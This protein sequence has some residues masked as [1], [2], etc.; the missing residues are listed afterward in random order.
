MTKE[1]RDGRK[2]RGLDRDAK[3]DIWHHGCEEGESPAEV[4]AR[5]DRL[6]ENIKEIQGPFLK[7]SGG[8]QTEGSKDV[9]IIAHG[10]I[11]RAF[12]KRWVQYELKMR[13]PMMLEP[14]AVGVLSYEHHSVEEPA[15]L[16]GI[17]MGGDMEE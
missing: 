4:E 8:T 1:I 17:N 16:L 2:Q 3:W 12:A 14:G 15:L 5:L 9:V 13:L 6:I 7:A 10:H 11:L